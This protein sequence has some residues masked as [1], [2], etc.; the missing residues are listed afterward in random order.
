MIWPL[1][2]VFEL[3]SSIV[4]T[5]CHKFHEKAGTEAGAPKKHRKDCGGPREH[6][7]QGWSS[8]VQAL[9]MVSFSSEPSMSKTVAFAASA[10]VSSR[11][12]VSSQM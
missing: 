8:H 12:R 6:L 5:S 7:D 4:L 11:P 10:I 3:G 1:R 9:A 2:E